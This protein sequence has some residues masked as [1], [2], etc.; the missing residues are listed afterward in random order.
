MLAWMC[1][2]FRLSSE[3]FLLF[4]LNLGFGFGYFVVTPKHSDSW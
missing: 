1:D 4:L 3:I 2:V